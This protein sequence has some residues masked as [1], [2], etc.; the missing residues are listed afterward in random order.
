MNG[1]KTQN[2]K[3]CLAAF[4]ALLA[5]EVIADPLLSIDITLADGE[6]FPAAVKVVKAAGAN[7]TSLSLF[8]DDQET[9]PSVFAPK[10]NWPTIAN[11]YFPSTGLAYTLTFSVIDTVADRRPPDLRGLAWDD[12]LVISRFIA[13]VDA[14]LGKMPRVQFK[15]IAIGNEVDVFLTSPDDVAAYARFLTA[16]HEH[17]ATTRPGVPV[18]AKITFAGITGDP[19]RLTPI[20]QAGD[21]AFFTYYPLN[22]DFTLRA[23]TDA[24]HDLDVM[25]DLAGGKPLWLL[26]TGY[27]SNGCNVPEGGQEIFFNTLLAAVSRHKDAIA[28][29]SATYLT[30]L[31]ETV[32]T[33]FS[34]YY[35]IG[36]D[37]FARYLGSLGLRQFDGTAKPA[38]AALIH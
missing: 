36:G 3:L 15:S 30:D 5:T 13:H 38:L 9:E 28:L 37:C 29:V 17:L 20:L 31:P 4:A 22:P 14:V 7:A 19:A 25:L 21:A 24:T 34:D 10:D 11:L 33:G 32:V 6:D 8:W 1:K 26:E 23:P 16:V 12:P 35:G 18:A 2:L 27:P